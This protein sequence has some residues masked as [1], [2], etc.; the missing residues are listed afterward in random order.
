[1]LIRV[2]WVV[3]VAVAALVCS[4][5][6]VVAGEP[7]GAAPTPKSSASWE[8]RLLGVHGPKLKALQEFP[9]K[10]RVTLAI[11]GQGGVS[12]KHLEGYF[13]GGNTLSYHGCSDPGQPTH[14]NG[15]LGVILDITDVLGVEVD[16]H[17]WQPGTPFVDVADRFREA[18]KIADVV[19]FFQSFWGTDAKLISEAIRESP[20]ALFLSP[21]VESGQ[22]PTS[23]APQGSACKPWVTES[24][25][26]FVLAA[27]LARRASAGNIITP[28]DRDA[29]DSE[30]INFI[31]PSYHAS[32]P[33]GTCPAS[34]TATA[35][36]IYLYAV[37]P[38]RPKP[39]EVI[40]LMRSTSKVDAELL[41]SVPEFDQESVG[42]LEKQVQS[43]RAPV[44]GK[45]RKLDAPGML[46]LF[47][48][49]QEVAASTP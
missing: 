10:R 21:Y 16:V 38:E 17:V 18:A 26:H 34:A 19:S 28:T 31:A 3:W 36:A 20:S 9:K 1:M 11:V 2:N 33:G 32:G 49:Y 41:T 24:I 23:E 5:G 25:P 8:L 12:K 47:D 40:E 15:Q 48:A 6:S 14:D 27:P 42:R 46:N 22:R 44:Q 4:A 35:C 30:A 43:L 39:D 37:M 29:T 45:Q 7:T 13:T